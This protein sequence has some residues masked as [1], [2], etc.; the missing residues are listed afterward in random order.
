MGNLE[1]QVE[2]H[3]ER[4]DQMSIEISQVERRL[5]KLDKACK[6]QRTLRVFSISPGTL[7]ELE[8]RGEIKELKEYR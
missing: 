6:K 7:E 1:H 3:E 4:L 2:E 8:S 5:A